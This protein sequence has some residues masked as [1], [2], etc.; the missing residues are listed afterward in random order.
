[1]Q[2]EMHVLSVGGGVL[3]D[4]GTVWANAVVLDTEQNNFCDS[5]RFDKGVKVA[6]VNIS[7]DNDNEV[8]KRFFNEDFPA[9][10]ILDIQSSV[11]KGALVMKINNF[12][13]NRKG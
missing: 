5:S 2:V 4:N 6:K 10:F 1:M 12:K 7:T 8:A 11:K 13:S 9:S 3:E